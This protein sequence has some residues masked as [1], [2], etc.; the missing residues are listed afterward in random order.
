MKANSILKIACITL[1]AGIFTAGC[2]NSQQQP[3]KKVNLPVFDAQGHRGARGLMPENTVPAMLRAIDLGVTTLEMDCHITKDKQVVLAHDDHINLA[4]ALTPDG[5]E[6]PNG[7]SKKYAIYQLDYAEVQ[8]FD[9]G[10]KVHDK[11]PQ[12]QKLKVHIPLLSAVIDSVQAYLRTNNKPQVFYNI[13]TKSKPTGDNV[14]HP[15]PEEFVRLL[16]DVIE[17]KQLESWVTIQSFDI[18]TLKEMNRKYPHVNTS[19]LTEKETSFEEN[20]RSL[21]FIPTVYSPNFKLVT[22]D[23]VKKCHEKGM[24]IVPWTVNSKEE[25]VKL[26]ALGVDGIITDYPNLFS[27]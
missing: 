6:I 18:R 5:K 20:L 14:L 27:E 26:K 3:R 9:V 7:D 24:K 10:S 11:F 4:F 22:A 16:M 15:D 12:Q 19:F 2:A 1:A 8:R 21:G 23:L 17:S 25:I 13:E